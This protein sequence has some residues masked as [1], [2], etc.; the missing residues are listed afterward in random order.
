MVSFELSK[1]NFCSALTPGRQIPKFLL[2]RIEMQIYW[3]QKVC[4]R[5]SHESISD[6]A[7]R[8]FNSTELTGMLLLIL[9]VKSV[10]C[11]YF[12]ILKFQE[13]FNRG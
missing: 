8:I 5:P 10:V 3:L 4:N 2:Q 11:K 9:S 7:V 13:D 1:E 12:Q 6:A